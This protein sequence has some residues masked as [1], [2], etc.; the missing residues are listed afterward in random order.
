MKK[1]IAIILSAIAILAVAV[2]L[3]LVFLLPKDKVKNE[4]VHAYDT[5]W[6]NDGEYHWYECQND[7]CDAKEKDKA[8]HEDN[9]G[10]G[11]CDICGYKMK[12]ISQTVAVESVTI[13]KNELTLTAGDSETLTVNILPVN[14]TDKSVSWTSSDNAKVTV[15]DGLVKAVSAGTA[16]ITVKTSNNKTAKCKV[17]VKHK[18]VFAE[19]V[20]LNK[21]VLTLTVGDSETLTATL[22]PS[23]VTDGTL[24]WD[25][26]D[27]TKVTVTDGTVTAVALGEATITVKTANGK[28]ASCV[29]TVELPVV[30]VESI[31]INKTT[32]TLTVGDSETLTVN[33]L[34]NNATD[35][36]VNWNS[37]DINKVTVNSNGLVT[38]VAAGE[39]TITVRTANGKTASCAVTVELPAVAVESITVNKSQLNLIVG[40]TETLTVTILPDTATD[41]EVVWNSSDTSK[42]TVNSNGLVTA[43][44]IGTATVTVTSSNGKTAECAIS[45]GEPSTQELTYSEIKEGEDV[46]AYSVSGISS[47]SVSGII[48]PSTYSGKPVTAIA[49]SAFN[50]CNSLGSL[51][52]PSSITQIGASVLPGSSGNS[53]RSVRYNGDL[54]SWCAIPDVSGVY[55]SKTYIYVDNSRLDQITSLTIPDSVES[56]GA[57]AFYSCQKLKTL[58]L[59]SSLRN[60]GDGAFNGSNDGNMT[61]NFA[62]S[63]SDWCE[64]EGQKSLRPNGTQ[65][66]IINIDGKSLSTFTNVVIPDGVTKISGYAFYPGYGKTNSLTSVVLPD[67]VTEIG[68]RAFEGSDSLEYIV[69]GKNVTKIGD[70][71]FKEA[72]ITEVYFT[73]TQ[74]EWNGIDISSAT[75]NVRVSQT[76][77]VQVNGNGTLNAATKYYY[78]E[79]Q[80]TEEGNYWHYDTDGVTPVKWE[81]V[82]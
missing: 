32:L 21:N 15:S 39:A 33:V 80:P 29:I 22:F 48:I 82:E 50:Q 24:I 37:S 81:T 78:S 75:Y 59:P 56:I 7:G 14:A 71:A 23:D 10:D 46:V 18:E 28:T 61:I 74:E 57:Y 9:N 51:T 4:H 52:I 30:A 54:A 55:A 53:Y 79:S 35:K 8:K 13:N 70:Y 38:A 44:A 45:V 20:N 40:D 31:S 41:K 49:D 2:T 6:S 25:S 64:L 34:P 67:S 43:V 72:A 3:L 26:S 73:G 36:T 27:N 17:T 47:N 11:K 16:T 62:G 12:D 1:K 58:N 65:N 76:Q 19:S 5:E 68:E 69:I 77:V 42:V 66:W 60:V 63:L